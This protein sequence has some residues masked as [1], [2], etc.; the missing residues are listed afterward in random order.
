M[1]EPTQFDKTQIRDAINTAA[2]VV[3]ACT[4]VPVDFQHIDT[5]RDSLETLSPACGGDTYFARRLGHFCG[6]LRSCG[7]LRI[8]PS[9]P[10]SSEGIMEAAKQLTQLLAENS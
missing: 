1:S 7:I 6:S 9:K 5:L 2:A 4:Q 8:P 3:Y 10:R